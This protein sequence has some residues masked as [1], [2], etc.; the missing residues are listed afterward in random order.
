MTGWTLTLGS[1]AEQDFVDILVWTTQTFGPQQAEIYQARLIALTEALE[2]DPFQVAS[3]PRDEIGQGLLTLH[4]GAKKIRGRHLVLY[5]IVDREIQVLRFLHDAMEIARHLPVDDGL[6][7]KDS[8]SE[9]QRPQLRK[10]H[11]LF[12]KIVSYIFGELSIDVSKL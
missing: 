11:K 3:K 8:G 6:A 7:G 5:R 2:Q 10:P 9:C 1:V 4:M 12:A